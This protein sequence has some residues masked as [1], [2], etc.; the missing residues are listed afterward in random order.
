MADLLENYN[1]KIRRFAASGFQCYCKNVIT[2][3][4]C[5]HFRPDYTN[6]YS[7]FREKCK[8]QKCHYIFLPRLPLLTKPKIFANPI[9]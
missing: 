7:D 9:K 4:A 2:G 5:L 8:H 6:F 3:I 1:K